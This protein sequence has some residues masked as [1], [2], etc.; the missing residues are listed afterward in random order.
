MAAAQPIVARVRGLGRRSCSR[1]R[2]SA[3]LDDTRVFVLCF[4]IDHYM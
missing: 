3:R 2:Q 4:S 1:H